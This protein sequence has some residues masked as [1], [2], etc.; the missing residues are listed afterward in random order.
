MISKLPNEC[1]QQI[2]RDIEDINTLY[3]I[4]QVDHTWCENGI[5]YLWKNPFRN[6]IK[7]KNQIKIIPI[8]LG[9][10][11]KGENTLFDYPCLITH[12]N[13]DNLIKIVTEFS[14]INI[15]LFKSFIVLMEKDETLSLIF[16]NIKFSKWSEFGQIW[17]INLLILVNMAKRKGSIRWFKI[18]KIIDRME[19]EN[20]YNN[21]DNNEL[22]IDHKMEDIFTIF[23]KFDE[24]KK[25][26]EN[27]EFLE[28]GQLN[29]NNYPSLDSLS[30]IC[31]KLKTI[32]IEGD[33]RSIYKPLVSLI[34]YQKNLEI[35][36]IIG[37][38]NN[39][40]MWFYEKN[41]FEIFSSLESI[42]HSI[43]RFEISGIEM[44]KDETFEFLGK[45]KNLEILR[46]EDS[47][48]SHKNFEWIAKAELSK[49]HSLELISNCDGVDFM[50]Q[51][52]PIQG[53]LKNK[54]IS[55][56]LKKLYLRNKFLKNY[57][58]LEAIGENC[59]NLVNFS[60]QL[61]ANNDITTLNTI[62]ENNSNIKE[63]YLNI[64]LDMHTVDINT[65]IIMDL[66]K[67]LPER[68]HTVQLELLINCVYYCRIFLENCLVNL[69]YFYIII[70]IDNDIYEFMNCIESWS[71][72][73]GKQIMELSYYPNY[74]NFC[75]KIDVVWDEN[76]TIIW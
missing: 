19:N 6:D 9:F 35:L 24:S 64:Y 71:R 17:V 3:S 7:I 51:I 37:V 42:A 66:A 5:I 50:R 70:S 59:R 75:N 69:K 12:L 33:F 39:S 11:K 36:Q 38:K 4:I 41:I 28:C 52:N 31:R 20:G 56:N 23:L 16:R 61:T 10:L 45:C 2:F 22:I 60:T 58:L 47:N 62:L 21:L 72:E 26:F 76:L 34:K 53:I 29:N 68:I 54:I 1:L 63:L 44:M 32:R 48:I 40:G 14:K 30:K 25:F 74:A 55:S 73:R 49:L 13:L 43:K 67:S 46:L 18:D 15:N 27:L 57:D 65:E 8:L